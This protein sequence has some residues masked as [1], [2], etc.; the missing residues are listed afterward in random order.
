MTEQDESRDKRM[1]ELRNHLAV[2]AGYAEMLL[3]TMPAGT[4]EHEDIVSI[5]DAAN[6]A[7]EITRSLQ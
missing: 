6:A 1:H 2:I 3:S 7:I 4:P 5:R